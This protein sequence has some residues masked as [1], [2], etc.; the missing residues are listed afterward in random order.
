MPGTGLHHSMVPEWR[1]LLHRSRDKRDDICSPGRPVGDRP[2]ACP[3]RRLPAHRYTPP[4]HGSDVVNVCRPPDHLRRPHPGWFHFCPAA[5][6]SADIRPVRVKAAL[7]ITLDMSLDGLILNV[8][9]ALTK[10]LFR[11]SPVLQRQFRVGEV[12]WWNLICGTLALAV[13]FTHKLEWI[14]K[15]TS[16]APTGMS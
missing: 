16:P 7:E 5:C 6:S 1:Q 14:R 2:A 13:V 9:V 4:P 11:G 15:L 3:G 8:P 12:N 10:G